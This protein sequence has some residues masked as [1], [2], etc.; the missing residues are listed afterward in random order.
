MC[1]FVNFDGYLF[2]MS[3][4]FV[5]CWW[6]LYF[7]VYFWLWLDYLLLFACFLV[8]IWWFVFPSCCL[9]CLLI[10]WILVI[11]SG[12]CLWLFGVCWFGESVDL[13]V[14]LFF[15]CVS[16]FGLFVLV[17]AKLDLCLIVL[18]LFSSFNLDYVYC[19]FLYLCLV[20]FYW[21]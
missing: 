7:I 20:W 21:F 6:L 8:V 11:D 16:T 13:W 9:C 15:V 3:A 4:V 10:S 5:V 18:W 1:L 12:D 14:C 17:M 2:D 19:L